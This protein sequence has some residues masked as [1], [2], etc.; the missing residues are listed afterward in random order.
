MITKQSI[1]SDELISELLSSTFWLLF[2][3]DAF[4]TKDLPSRNRFKTMLNYSIFFL[5]Y[6]FVENAVDFNKT[7]IVKLTLYLFST[8]NKQSPMFWKETCKGEFK[9]L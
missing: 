2:G 6:P 3:Q 5:T 8:V 7:V 9:K 1:S 4:Q